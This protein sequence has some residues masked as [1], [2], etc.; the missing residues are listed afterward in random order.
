MKTYPTSLQ[1][2]IFSLFLSILSGSAIA[3]NTKTIGF[4]IGLPEQQTSKNTGGSTSIKG[5]LNYKWIFG[6]NYQKEIAS[7]LYL[8]LD[9]STTRA[10]HEIALSEIMETSDRDKENMFETYQL[11]PILRKEFPLFSKFGVQASLG[12]LGSYIDH[13]KRDYVNFEFEKVLVTYVP[14]GNG[15]TQRKALNDVIFN[16]TVEAESKFNV[17]IRPELGLYFNT[18]TR[19]KITLDVL[20]GAYLG[21]PVLKRNYT[22]LIHEGKSYTASDSFSGSYTTL[23]LGYRYFIN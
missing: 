14:D 4:R 21:S 2:V 9:F 23:M 5:T 8:G 17:L 7:G 3:Q 22:N 15:G 13:Q 20:Y 12:V 18:G 1:A 19:G 11:G 10:S 6:L 16:G